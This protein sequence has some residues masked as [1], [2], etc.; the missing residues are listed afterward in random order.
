MTAVL[1]TGDTG[2]VS[3]ANPLVFEKWGSHGG[4]R[5]TRSRAFHA[6]GR[7]GAAR[8]ISFCE[9]Q[10]TTLRA[11]ATRMSAFPHNRR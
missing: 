4:L 1:A 3:P 2:E 11:T 6:W 10:E 5:H 7:R 9:T 8:W